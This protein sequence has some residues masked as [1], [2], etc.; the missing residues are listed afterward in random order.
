[1]ASKPACSEKILILRSADDVPARLIEQLRQLGDVQVETELDA[2]FAA[3]VAEKFDVVVG[4]A[5]TLLAVEHA[6]MNPQLSAVLQA[7]GQ[8]ICILHPDG[9]IVWSNARMKS[10]PAMVWDRI[11]DE[12]KQ[13][14]CHDLTP[15]SARRLR[16]LSLATEE[17][18]HFDATINAFA[19]GDSYRLVLIVSDVTRARRLQQ[20]MDAIDNAGRELVRVDDE[21]LA[22]MDMRQ[23]LDLLEQKII[24]YTRELLHF[25][26]FAVRLLDKNTNKLEII[27]AT[28]LPEVA[29]AV[30]FYASTE[31]NGISG[32]VAATGR[33]YICP[34]VRKDPRYVAGIDAACS[35]LTVPL[36]LHDQ[37]V[38]ILNIESQKTA[39]FSE[40]DRQFAEIFGRYI[41]IALH[42]LNV[43]VVDRHKTSDQLADNVTAEIAG[44]LGEILA[45]ASTLAEDY[46]GH[47]DLRRRLGHIVDNVARIKETVK[48]VTRPAGGI[49][50]MRTPTPRR[51]ETLRGKSL[52][53][54]DDEEIIRHTV[55]DVLSDAGCEIETAREGAEALALIR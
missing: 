35:S 5:R 41:A 8:G 25:D 38:G 10:L 4:P 53:V 21:Q 45:D 54:I 55:R 13:C 44:P 52:L 46:I 17:D 39:A 30:D 2:A 32:Y 7:I 47:D 40:D 6:A 12:C 1:M 3:A 33:S 11:L 37:V 24:R 29:M 14:E 42:I 48:Q 51:D 16:S 28:G 36:R 9:Q 22:K 19:H 31:N 49:L 27:S 43:L 18:Q 26:N 20:K 23:R 15:E 34:D 50:G